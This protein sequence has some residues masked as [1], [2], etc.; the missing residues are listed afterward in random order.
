MSKQQ[1]RR[2]VVCPGADGWKPAR[3]CVRKADGCTPSRCTRSCAPA[4]DASSASPPTRSSSAVRQC[5]AHGISILTPGRRVATTLLV[6]PQNLGA[7]GHPH[8]RLPQ[9]ITAIRQSE[10]LGP[11]PEH[12][13]LTTQK[14]GNQVFPYTRVS[15]PPCTAILLSS[16]NVILST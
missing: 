3:G 5:A 10:V 13:L 9:P 4:G 2:L 11:Q 1:M 15:E 12:S 16:S 14:L 6:S 8:L 7:S